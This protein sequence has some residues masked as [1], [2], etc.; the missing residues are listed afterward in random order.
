M[1]PVFWNY[2][3]VSLQ[4]ILFQN[5]IHLFLNVTLYSQFN[6]IIECQQI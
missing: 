5:V 4:S 1:T 3:P 2:V 6:I